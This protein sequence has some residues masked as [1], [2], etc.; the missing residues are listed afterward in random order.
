MSNTYNWVISHLDCY[1]QHN[2]KQDVV[3]NVHWRRQASDGLHMAD[4]YGTQAI[5][6]NPSAPFTLFADLTQLQIGGW[7]EDAMGA[8]RLA[9]IDAVLDGQI[10]DQINPPVVTLPTPWGE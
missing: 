5:A 3:F 9:E 1:P 4:V 8:D 2:G 7:L 6:F 10:S